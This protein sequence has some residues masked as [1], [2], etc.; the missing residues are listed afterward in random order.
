MSQRF[1]YVKYDQES[2][3][4][5]EKFK[6]AFEILEAMGNDLLVASRPQSLFLTALEEAYMW[7]G[8]SIRDEQI[9]RNSLVAHTPERG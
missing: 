8:K 9:A 3:D 1:T 7:T 6:K 5:Q 2:T 4:K